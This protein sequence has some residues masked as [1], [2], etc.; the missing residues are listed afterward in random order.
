MSKK[1]V[2]Q[3]RAV[4]RATKALKHAKKRN[5]SEYRV[6]RIQAHID[7][8]KAGKPPVALAARGAQ[9]TEDKARKQEAAAKGKKTEPTAWITLYYVNPETRSAVQGQ[10]HVRFMAAQ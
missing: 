10:P 8:V 2:R 7:A 5:A 9:R 3:K 6:S 4:Q 1:E